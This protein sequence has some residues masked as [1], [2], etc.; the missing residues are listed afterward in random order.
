[1]ANEKT[2]DL[3]DN[4]I[5]DDSSDNNIGDD[6]YYDDAKD[7]PMLIEAQEAQKE[8]DAQ[9]GEAKEG[10]E[11]EQGAE[12]DDEADSEEQSKSGE[13]EDD[14][15]IRI[16]KARLDE[17]LSKAELYRNQVAY[18]Q[19]LV[20]AQGKRT[21]TAQDPD[22]ETAQ[23]T[24]NQDD[25]NDQSVDDLD[26]AIQKALDKKLELAER[27]DE[28]ELSTK[29]WKQQ[30]N[31][32]DAEIRKLDQERIEQVR[33]ESKEIAEQ[34]WNQH[35]LQ[36]RIASEAIKIQEQHPSIV[37][38]DSYPETFS[39]VIWSEIDAKAAQSL[40]NKGV[41]LNDGSVDTRIAYMKEKAAIADQ[42]TPDKIAQML[43]GQ[44]N[45]SE[46]SQG[47]KSGLSDRAQQRSEKLDLAQSLPPSVSDMGKGDSGDG[48]LTE[49][50]IERMSEDEIADMLEKQ[51]QRIQKFLGQI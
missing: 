12:S 46:Q 18:L 28:G 32:I 15:D 30:E 50:Q 20:D 41:N 8:L 23:Q 35:N 29:D 43:S 49:A 26:A 47:N 4:Q 5:L 21:D 22:D 39:R 33:A 37:V 40:A 51:P 36:Q 48:E 34:T 42:Y 31:E 3:K 38:I 19:G 16:P 44:K 45:Q 10:E 9:K 25:A 2:D 6:E 14:K 27:Y 17:A 24:A 11:T 1:M 13:G 7:D